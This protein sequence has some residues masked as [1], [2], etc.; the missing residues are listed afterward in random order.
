MASLSRNSTA[1]SATI[2]NASGNSFWGHLP[3][4]FW[5]HFMQQFLEILLSDIF[6]I[7]KCYT[8][9]SSFWYHF[10][11]PD[12]F[13]YHFLSWCSWHTVLMPPYYTSAV[14]TDTLWYT[15]LHL[16]KTRVKG[17]TALV[18][19]LM[20]VKIVSGSHRWCLEF[21]SYTSFHISFSFIRSLVE[22]NSQYFKEHETVLL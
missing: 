15:R 19:L 14:P 17:S 3:C 16:L 10:I 2:G 7:G 5:Q 22:Y 4:H 9:F 18:K 13:I 20:S 1:H 11:F 21:K 6:F 8:L 12:K